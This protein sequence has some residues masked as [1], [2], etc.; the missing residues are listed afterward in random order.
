M[1]HEN[2]IIQTRQQ[3]LDEQARLQQEC[4]GR[5]LQIT[6]TKET[7]MEQMQTQHRKE[8]S[9]LNQRVAIATAEKQHMRQDLRDLSQVA[10]SPG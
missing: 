7:E 2:E 1:K 8:V 9:D 10:I 3:H 5:I 4:E 6:T